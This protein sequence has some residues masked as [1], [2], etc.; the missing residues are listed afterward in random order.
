MLQ[1]LKV[2]NITEQSI[3]W[4]KSTFVTEYYFVKAEYRLCD[5]GEISCGVLKAP[6]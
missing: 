2:I 6:L 3:Q 1:K 4:F 5:F